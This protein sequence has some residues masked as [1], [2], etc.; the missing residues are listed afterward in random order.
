MQVP[1]TRTVQNT[2][3]GGE[4]NDTEPVPRPDTDTDP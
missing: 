2:I 1:R 3:A 4:K